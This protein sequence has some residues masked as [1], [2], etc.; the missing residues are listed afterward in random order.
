[1]TYPDGHEGWLVTSYAAGRAILADTRFSSRAE[2]RHFLV[3]T[4][5]PQNEAKP[6]APGAISRLDPP[7][8]TH[9]RRM[10]TGKFTVRR[11]KQLEPGIQKITEDHIEA[12]RRQGP[13][14]IWSRRSRCPSLPW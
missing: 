12:M 2:L 4:P 6:A 13:P 10:L 8:H 1:M 7:E 5:Y 11:L 3:P 9:Y 14:S